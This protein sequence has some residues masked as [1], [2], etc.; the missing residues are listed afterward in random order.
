MGARDETRG[1]E[2]VSRIEAK[3]ES[4]SKAGSVHWV[5]IDVSTP[6]KA[7]AGAQAFLALETKLDVLI[8][9]AGL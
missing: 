5:P 4:S 8:N 3:I 6:L 9:N 2:A 1:K 7:K